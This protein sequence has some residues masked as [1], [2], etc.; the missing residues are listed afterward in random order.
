MI[1][2]KAA[3]SSEVCAVIISVSGEVETGVMME[4]CQHVVD[5]KGMLDKWRTRVLVPCRFSK[6]C[7][8]KSCNACRGVKLLGNSL[9][10]AESTG[11]K[12]SRI[13]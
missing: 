10:I 3:G 9:K 12:D 2:G 7:N 5:G 8:G 1:P 11:K 6:N 13:S 4:L